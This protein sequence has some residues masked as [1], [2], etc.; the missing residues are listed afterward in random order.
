[1]LILIEREYKES[2]MRRFGHRACPSKTKEKLT[3]KVV[4]TFKFTVGKPVKLSL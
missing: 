4:D 1:M 2:S 3:E